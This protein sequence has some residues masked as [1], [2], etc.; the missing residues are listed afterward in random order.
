MSL[1]DDATLAAI[2]ECSVGSEPVACP[3]PEGGNPLDYS[4][5]EH[6]EEADAALEAVLRAERDEDDAAA[7]H[8]LMQAD[9]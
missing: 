8:A 4:P 9:W 7:Y 6:D 1:R 3:D 5:R 2:H